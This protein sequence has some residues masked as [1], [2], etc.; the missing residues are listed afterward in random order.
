[1]HKIQHEPKIKHAPNLRVKYFAL[2]RSLNSAEPVAKGL[3]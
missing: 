3:M 2:I 1:M